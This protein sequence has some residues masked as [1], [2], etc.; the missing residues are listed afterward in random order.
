MGPHSFE[1]GDENRLCNAYPAI[2]ASMGPHSFER[3]DAADNPLLPPVAFGFN[4]AALFRARRSSCS[5]PAWCRFNCFNG[6]AL[7][8]ARRWPLRNPFYVK[9]PFE[10]LREAKF[11]AA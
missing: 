9:E 6:A 11:G 10:N 4:G 5:R 1:R 8:R 3:G 2:A 7:F